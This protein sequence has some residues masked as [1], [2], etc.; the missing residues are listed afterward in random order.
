MN[1]Y[2]PNCSKGKKSLKDDINNFIEKEDKVT[3][4][5]KMIENEKTISLFIFL[6]FNVIFSR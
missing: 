6:I 2:S 5:K 4:N 1:V 3:E